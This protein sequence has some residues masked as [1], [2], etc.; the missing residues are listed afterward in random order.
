VT[1]FHTTRPLRRLALAA[2]VAGASAAVALLM[3]AS[4]SSAAMS[5]HPLSPK[6]VAFTRAMDK[7]WEDHITWT[8][9]VIVDFAAGAPDLKLAE[10][11]LLRNQADIGSAVKPYYG[12]AAGKK[13]TQLLRTHILEA[14]PVLTYAKEG[15]QAKLKQALTAWYANAHQI[16]VF[17][18]QANPK[19]WPRAAM[20]KMMKRH[21]ALTTDEGVARIEGHWQADIAAYDKVHREILQMSNMLSG[22]IIAQFPNRF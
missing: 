11:R 16:A 3:T 22:G 2:A 20:V 14:V 13:L 10:A 12:P 18:S 1:A 4:H 5:G 6:A 19:N 15:D 17:L 9:M 7:L 8:R 21:L